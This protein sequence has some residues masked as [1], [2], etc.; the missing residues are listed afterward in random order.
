MTEV[1]IPKL[2]ATDTNKLSLREGGITVFVGANGSGK[3]RL[4]ALLDERI[5]VT[6]RP[7]H[8]ISAHRALVIPEEL[9]VISEGLARHQFT[10][11]ASGRTFEA[12]WQ[13]KIAGRWGNEPA[14]WLSND[15]DRALLLLFA[16]ENRLANQFLSDA[17]VG[18]IQEPPES[19]LKRLRDVWNEIMPPPALTD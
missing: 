12:N 1:D 6:G 15:F 14:T 16:V 4:V 7:S 18:N 17:R 8:R 2:D 10:Y 5:E 13:T 11:A 9:Q 3:T 19:P